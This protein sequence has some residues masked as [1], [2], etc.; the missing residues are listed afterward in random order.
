MMNF[1][2]L[3]RNTAH[4][5][6]VQFLRLLAFSLLLLGASACTP[7]PDLAG[8][9]TASSELASDVGTVNKDTSERLQ[10]VVQRLEVCEA[11]KCVLTEARKSTDWKR[12]YNSFV[13]NTSTI[14]AT[15]EAMV[16]YA[17]AIAALAAK[18]ETGR[19][20]ARSILTSV[21]SILE[22]VGQAY[23][24]AAPFGPVIEEVGA[25]ITK[26]EAQES[27]A[28]Q[29]HVLEVR[30]GAI[31]KLVTGLTLASAAQI[32]I[33]DEL[34]RLEVDLL[35]A[36]AGP[37]LIGWHNH[38]LGGTAY[39]IR[40]ELFG[41]SDVSRLHDELGLLALTEKTV[42]IYRRGLTE[43]EAWSLQRVASLEKIPAAAAVWGETHSEAR[44]ILQKCGG[45]RSLKWSCGNYSAANLVI[46][47]KR[48][49]NLVQPF[50]EDENS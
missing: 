37:E 23:P 39:K 41:A 28:R 9:A 24:L 11:Q 32:K 7:T 12:K 2:S 44:E 14:D 40:E 5:L 31:D 15:M 38:Q 49:K 1:L 21:K 48:I 19:D 17:D 26:A 16:L 43:S 35:E 46:A 18:G 13:E 45:I 20:A 50:L 47:G 33:V 34:Y 42:A 36:E 30:G 22:T 3:K 25:L 10:S 29:M 8:W 27:L 6:E 4:F